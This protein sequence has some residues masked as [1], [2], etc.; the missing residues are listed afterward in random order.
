MSK[1]FVISTA[2]NLHVSQLN[3]SH[4]QEKMSPTMSTTSG[5]PA[6]NGSLV[7]SNT[8]I[9]WTPD[10]HEKFVECMNRLGGAESK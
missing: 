4:E 3:F 7:S 1:G 8:R 6:S 5:N 2:Y 9:T 10:L